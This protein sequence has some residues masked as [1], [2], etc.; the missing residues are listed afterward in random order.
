[1]NYGL[2]VVTTDSAWI[3]PK[4]GDCNFSD[5]V[6][7][8][9]DTSVGSY[10]PNDKNVVP[11]GNIDTATKTLDFLIRF[12][13]T[14]TAP[15]HNVRIDDVIDSKIDLES[16][17]I[18]GLSHEGYMIKQEN[19]MVVFEFPNIMLPDSGTDQEGSNGYVSFKANLINGIEVGDEI[20]NTA[21][22]FFD[23]NDPIIT[24]T[25]INKVVLDANSRIINKD[26]GYEV[27]IYPNPISDQTTTFEIVLDKSASLGLNLYDLQ[28]RL[29]WNFEKEHTNKHFKM[30][31]PWNDLIKGMYLLEIKIN[32]NTTDVIR[33]EK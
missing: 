24:N 18:T 33:I 4:S 28:G 12:Q 19:R 10:D 31:L 29:L 15:A 20:K 3:E 25:T 2:G 14:G 17:I 7:K 5:N 1:V 32:Q 13:N 21:A 22:I 16:I 8:I 27:R 30:Q 9:T 26:K 11:S 23:F 6:S